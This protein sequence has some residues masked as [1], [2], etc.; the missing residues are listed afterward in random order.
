M[1]IIECNAPNITCKV[2][3]GNNCENSW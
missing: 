2:L 3:V 1:K